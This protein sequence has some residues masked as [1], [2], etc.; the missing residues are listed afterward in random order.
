MNNK[1]FISYRREDSSW[2]TGRI[3]D[4]LAKHFPDEQL[5]IDV[6]SI[7]PGDDFVSYIEESVNNCDVLLAVIGQRWLET[8]Q[9]KSAEI[10]FVRLEISA[11]LK[12]N[13]RIIPILVENTM[14]PS[15]KDLP[16]EL[17]ALTRRNAFLI[18][19]VSFNSEMET[20]VQS[21][22]KFFLQKKA[23][24]EE[25]KKEKIDDELRLK[26]V[27][28]AKNQKLNRGRRLRQVEQPGQNEAT[29]LNPAKFK[30]EKQQKLTAPDFKDKQEVI[31]NLKRLIAQGGQ[32]NFLILS[33]K[34]AYMQFAGVKGETQI[35]CETVSNN[36]LSKASKL[37]NDQIE[38]LVALGFSMPDNKTSNFVMPYDLNS[39]TDFEQL[40]QIVW[41]VFFDVH[42]FPESTKLSFKINLE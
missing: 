15:T 6:D 35:H 22:Q 1:I 32:G 3:Y 11:A 36:F 40:S 41:S 12:N 33:F 23:R 8:L 18:N 19:P 26:K 24:L 28:K 27:E 37:N 7:A 9:S 13:I 10:D 2:S 14:M 25:E 42:K 38:K 39:E 4:R 30:N 21:L 31:K 29:E 20:L 17:K 34:D 5:F 16:D